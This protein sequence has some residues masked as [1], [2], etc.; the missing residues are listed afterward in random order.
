MSSIIRKDDFSRGIDNVSSPNKL[1]PTR[2]GAFPV[3]DALNV[4][5]FS[6]GRIATRL[7]L[8]KVSEFEVFGDVAIPYRGRLVTPIKAEGGNTF[9]ASVDMS[10]STAY[11]LLTGLPPGPYRIKN[12]VVH[13]D[14]LY[15][16]LRSGYES[17]FI[18]YDGT[19][20][21]SW[22]VAPHKEWSATS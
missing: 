10:T 5:F 6:D 8:N 12:A 7:F 20:V 2:S 3:A 21:R 18:T 13:T 4:D 16:E 1:R 17:T 22:G 11:P 19:L 9:I 15:M 14:V